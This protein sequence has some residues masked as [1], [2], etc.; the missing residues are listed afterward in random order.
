MKSIYM[1][2][3]ILDR[4][5]QLPFLNLKLFGIIRKCQVKICLHPS[6]DRLYNE[7][8]K[9]GTAIIYMTQLA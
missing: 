2:D 7:Y 4:I 5:S 3:I 1:F 6:N 8:A 9:I